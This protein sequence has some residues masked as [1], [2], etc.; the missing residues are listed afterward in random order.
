MDDKVK[1]FLTRGKLKENPE[2]RNK[3]IDPGNRDPLKTKSITLLIINPGK[4][5]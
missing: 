3:S 4:E 5:I 1:E 2:L